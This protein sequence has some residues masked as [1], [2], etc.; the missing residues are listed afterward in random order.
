MNIEII[1]KM[2]MTRVNESLEYPK[3]KERPLRPHRSEDLGNSFSVNNAGLPLGS[4]GR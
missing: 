3:R 1:M 4:R 2:K